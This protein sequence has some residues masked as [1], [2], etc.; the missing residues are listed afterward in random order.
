MIASLCWL[1]SCKTS[2]QLSGS[3]GSHL[4]AVQDLSYKLRLRKLKGNNPYYYFESCS[5][6]SLHGNVCVPALIDEQGKAIKFELDLIDYSRLDQEQKKTLDS[7]HHDL[8]KI[9]STPKQSESSTDM[10]I[11]LKGVFNDRANGVFSVFSAMTPDDINNT[12]THLTNKLKD[13]D[14]PD[15]GQ[16]IKPTVSDQE[17]AKNDEQ[18][19]NPEVNQQQGLSA[20]EVQKMYNFMISL[21]KISQAGLNYISSKEDSDNKQPETI[22]D[23]GLSQGLASGFFDQANSILGIL[24]IAGYTPREFPGPIDPALPE[25]KDLDTLI[26]IKGS[27]FNE[28]PNVSHHLMSVKSILSTLVVHQ[29]QIWSS[30]ALGGLRIAKYCLPSTRSIKTLCYSP[31]NQQQ[32]HNDDYEYF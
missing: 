2:G 5:L 19:S 13:H 15:P 27:L 20:Q 6:I 26:S 18:L 24:K 8:E 22:T 4:Q 10:T 25:N 1:T 23:S 9:K 21:Q 30:T 12:V 16:V 29:D 31:F 28:D 3:D 7:T 32:D 14:L 17:V 11:D